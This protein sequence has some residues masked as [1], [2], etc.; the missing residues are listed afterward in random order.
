ASVKLDATAYLSPEKPKDVEAK[1]PAGDSTIAGYTFAGDSARFVNT[2]KEKGRDVPRTGSVTLWDSLKRIETD[3]IPEVREHKF[4][5]R[6]EQRMTWLAENGP[7]FGT[8]NGA[9]R[10]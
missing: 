3:L 6:P 10:H 8:D 9:L 5:K 7:Y 4:L 2:H 1:P